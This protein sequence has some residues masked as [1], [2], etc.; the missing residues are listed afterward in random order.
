MLSSIF[1]ETNEKKTLTADTG[2]GGPCY[3]LG[4]PVTPAL[5]HSKLALPVKLA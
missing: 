5:S 3:I 1:H 4:K 2:P